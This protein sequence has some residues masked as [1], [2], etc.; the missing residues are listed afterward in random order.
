[1]LTAGFLF[2]MSA[3]GGSTPAPAP[4]P[5]PQVEEVTPCHEQE[6]GGDEDAAEDV[7]MEEQVQE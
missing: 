7:Q 2:G 4:E 5:E 6:V 1:M 3:C